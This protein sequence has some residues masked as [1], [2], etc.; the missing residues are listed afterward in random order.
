[1]IALAVAPVTLFSEL[2]RTCGA[3]TIDRKRRRP[4][5]RRQTAVPRSDHAALTSRRNAPGLVPVH[6]RNAR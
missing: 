4:P 5:T 2:N 3:F 1:M 6:F